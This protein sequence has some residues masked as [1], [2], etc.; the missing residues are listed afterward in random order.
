MKVFFPRTSTAIT[1]SVHRTM[2]VATML[3]EIAKKVKVNASD[4]YLFMPSK[5]LVLEDEKLIGAYEF[6][7][8]KNQETVRMWRMIRLVFL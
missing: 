8:H 7:P 4:Y 6:V 1:F 3:D 2:S 5:E